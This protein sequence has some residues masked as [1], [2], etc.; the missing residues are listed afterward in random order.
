MKCLSE[1]RRKTSSMAASKFSPNLHA[2]A[3]LFIATDSNCKAGGFASFS[4]E[5]IPS[6]GFRKLFEA[7]LNYFLVDE[8]NQLF[9]YVSL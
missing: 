6:M 5:Y 8:G 1:F 9:S 3:L 2:S 4:L 7:V